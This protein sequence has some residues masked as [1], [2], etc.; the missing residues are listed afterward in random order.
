[1]MMIMM[2]TPFCDDDDDDDDDADP[3]LVSSLLAVVFGIEWCP[4]LSD[5]PVQLV[6]SSR[7]QA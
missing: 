1:M 2:P 3:F 5:V 7:A 6:Q 4:A